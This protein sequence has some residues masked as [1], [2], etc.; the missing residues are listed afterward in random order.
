MTESLLRT[1]EYRRTCVP[2]LRTTHPDVPPAL[3][4]VVRRCLAPFPGDR[5]E[6]ASQLAADLQAV[7]DDGPLRFAREPISSRSVRWLRRNRRRLA[8][9]APLILALGVSAYSLL[10]R[11]LAAVRRQA[12]VKQWVVTARHSV[13]VGQLELAS[14]QFALA[15]RL[16]EGDPWLRGLVDQIKADDQLAR[17]TKEAWDKADLLLAS[18]ERLRFSLLGFSGDSR[19]ACGRVE[20]RWQ[21][22][23]C[24]RNLSWLSQPSIT[25]LD[26]SRRARLVGEIDDLLFLW[27]V[28]LDGDTQRVRQAVR[29]C[30]TALRS[31]ASPGPWQ[32][33][34][35]RCAARLA[36]ETPPVGAL[37][38]TEAENSARGCFQWALLCNLEGKTESVVAWLERATRLEPRDYW[39]HF[40]L[41]DFYGRIG[42]NAR[43]M[44]HYQAA[45]ALRPDSP[46]ARCNRA[47][48]FHARGEWDLALDDLNQALASPQ[49]ADLL[50]ARLVLGLVKQVKG[51]D[52]GAR[53]A[54]DAV[55]AA[56]P[57]NPFASAARLNRAK[58]DIDAGQVDRAWAE[59][60]SLL[61]AD[62]R[63]V[64]ARLSRALLALR[65]GRATLADA[66]LSIL[67]QQAPERADE[68]LAARAR[69]RLLLGHKEDAETDAA[70]AL[71]PQAEFQPRTPLG[72]H[73]SRASPRRRPLMAQSP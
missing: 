53:S 63:D 5:Y 12:E 50:E 1:A 70:G 48:L 25:M 28:A 66:D 11:Q 10:R 13:A 16:A 72:P 54:Y 38:Q 59:Y 24:R 31:A 51:D 42:Q 20:E 27:V 68:I 49:G 41:G 15:V 36:G 7:A 2:R 40:Y 4:A 52:A 14:S 34:R 17:K 6:S 46:W 60:E 9:A 35:Q 19:I 33:I 26:E 23:P 29:I 69:V 57:G 21:S 67:L 32:A 62:P 39:S 44:E 55:I 8:V 58:L 45:V 18:G 61:A 73:A 56:G 64:P 43:A 37:T 3:E 47:L 22:S 65:F 30:D 71:P